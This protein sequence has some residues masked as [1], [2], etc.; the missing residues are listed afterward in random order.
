M[1]ISNNDE[2]AGKKKKTRIQTHLQLQQENK[3]LT[4]N[5]NNKKSTQNGLN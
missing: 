2:L 3:N 5:N 1:S 4:P